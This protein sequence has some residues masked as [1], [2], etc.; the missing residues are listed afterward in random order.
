[1]WKSVN[2]HDNLKL[3]VDVKE[4]ESQLIL[5]Y[6]LDWNWLALVDNLVHAFVGTS[7][8]LYIKIHSFIE[9]DVLIKF[10]FT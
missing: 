9:I 1:M 3:F 5:G 10:Q 4:S 8:S 6:Y 2:V 7:G